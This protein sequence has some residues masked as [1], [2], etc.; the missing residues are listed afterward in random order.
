MDSYLGLCL[1]VELS[2]H[3]FSVHED[4]Q[5]RP[6]HHPDVQLLHSFIKS[7]SCQH[8]LTS[9]MWMMSTCVVSLSLL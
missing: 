2:N 4:C 7:S 9:T 1:G 5:T 8:C 3:M 6:W